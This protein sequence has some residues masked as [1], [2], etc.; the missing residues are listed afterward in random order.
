MVV[1]ERA[2]S[3]AE[4]L[5]GLG[6]EEDQARVVDADRDPAPAQDLRGEDDPAAEATVP[7]ADTT[8]STS[9]AAPSPSGA[10][11]GGG[12]AG[13][14]PVA[15]RRWRSAVDRWERTDLIRAPATSRWM[16]SWSAQNETVI[17][18]RSGPSQ[19]CLPATARFP[20]AGTTR[21][22]STAPGT[23]AGTRSTGSG[24]GPSSGN[25]AGAGAAAR[26]AGSRRGNA[27]R[28]RAGTGA[29]RSAGDAISKDRCG[30]RVL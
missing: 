29:N 19:N 27:S 3:G 9:T 20:D 24:A 5:S 21:S 8:R 17:P 7:P 14:P 13:R 26:A 23:S 18:A 12:P 1:G 15:P 25:G 6:V 22:N 10:G 2:G 16:T 4:E 30:R 11:N 28:S